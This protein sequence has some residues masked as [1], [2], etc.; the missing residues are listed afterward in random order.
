MGT[1]KRNSSVELLKIIAVFGIVLAHTIQS[2]ENAG[3][4][5][6]LLATTNTKYFILI[7]L[8]YFGGNII[9]FVSSAYYLLNSEKVN[10]KKWFTLIVETWFISFIIL[11]IY[12]VADFNAI[13]KKE[14]IKSLFPITFGNNWYIT[15]YILFYPIHVLLNRIIRNIDKITHFRIVLFLT[16]IYLLICFIKQ[17]LFFATPII[18]WIVIY[19]IVA[20]FKLHLKSISSNLK[21]NILLLIFCICCH[22]GLIFLTN[23]LGLHISFFSNKMEH[24][25]AINNPF[26]I[27]GAIALINILSKKTYSNA[28]IN[29]I[30]KSTLLIYIIHENLLIRNHFRIDIVNMIYGKFGYDYLLS[31]IF[32]LGLLLFVI[33]LIIWL[34]YYKT[35]KQYVIIV[36]NS[37]FNIIKNNYIKIEKRMVNL[38]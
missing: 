26:L 9:F 18:T 24:W 11:V 15:C 12:S 27:F 25:G 6:P 37:L 8:R 2:F 38:R 23:I 7:V 19:F 32:V 16:I 28:F 36:S 22:I 1:T 17:N 4:I 31:E 29:Y 34:L 14:I 20:Y 13:T 21:Y 10:F 33:S 35:I 3:I 5:N 30:S